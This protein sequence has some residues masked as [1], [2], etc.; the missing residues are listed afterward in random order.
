MVKKFLY[1]FHGYRAE[2]HAYNNELYAMH[3]ATLKENDKLVGDD[4]GLQYNAMDLENQVAVENEYA[5]VNNI[6]YHYVK[7]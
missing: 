1:L 2:D 7:H 4:D 6:Q 5:S 3:P